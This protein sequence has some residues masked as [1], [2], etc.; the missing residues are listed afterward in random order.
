MILDAEGF[1]QLLQMSVS[2]EGKWNNPL[3]MNHLV[4]MKYS[5]REGGES[6][7]D[8]RE[9]DSPSVF[10]LLFWA[11]QKSNKQKIKEQKVSNKAKNRAKTK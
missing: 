10:W 2:N 8:R 7:F 11:M 6:L 3:S 1:S 5:A 4:K 9:F